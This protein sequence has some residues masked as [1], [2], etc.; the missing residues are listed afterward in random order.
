MFWSEG[1]D[2]NSNCLGGG[3]PPYSYLWDD[4]SS[5]TIATVEN[6]EAGRWYHVTITDENLQYV[7]DSV[8]LTQPDPMVI[9]KDYSNKICSGSNEGYISLGLTGGTLPFTF[10]WSSGDETNII[11]DLVPGKYSVTITDV[12]GCST[13]D[14]TII[15][16]LTTY[17]EADICLVTV[18]ND[19]MIMVVWEK[20]YGEGIAEYNIYRE[21]SLKD[22]YVKIASIPFDSLSVFI[23]VGSV[24]EEN[25]Y[26]YK[27]S[28]TD[29]CGNE[30]G[31]SP[32]HKSI[33]LVANIGLSSEVN[34]NWDEY[35]GFEYFNYEIYRGKSITELFSIRT[36]SAS[37]RSW[38]D[39]TAPSGQ[40]FYRILVVKPDPCFPT[41]LK[42]TE[43][44]SL[45]SNFDEETVIGINEH[46]SNGLLIYP[47]PFHDRTTI[48]FPNPEKKEYVIT[49][50][51]L[52]GQVVRT[53]SC[54][55]EQSEL[56]RDGLT[57][58]IYLIKLSGDIIFRGKLIIN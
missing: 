48:T 19:N 32:L 50:T 26:F 5:T 55:E 15:D 39:K 22:N 38:S 52:S 1:W 29:S 6:L 56:D 4:D 58:G 34:L 30:S 31:L 10:E 57:P 41:Q 35:V 8:M 40:N 12:N 42:S 33:H 18:N 36:I 14:S 51:N 37:I 49:I 43:I 53:F 54:W 45:F 20:T 44:N 16:S 28:I 17:Q 25:P 21:Q 11:N 24:P 47:N 23:D 2:C 7:T 27:I 9:N 46:H 3:A 13:M